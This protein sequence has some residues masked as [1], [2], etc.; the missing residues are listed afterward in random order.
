MFCESTLGV[1]SD[2][3][4]QGLTD[5]ELWFKL[6]E[7]PNFRIRTVKDVEGVCLCGGMKNII[8]LAA[9]FSDGLGWGSNTKAAII[10]IGLTEMKDFSLRFF[11]STQAETF[12]QESCG[13]ADLVTTCISGRNRMIGEEMAK[14]GKGFQELEREKLNGQ[15]LEGPQTVDQVHGFMVLHGD[16]VRKYG[17]YRLLENVWKICFQGLSPDKVL[18]GV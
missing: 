12:F 5:S 14:S 3:P 15:Q 2:A 13:V 10:R 6:F 1:P 18:E 11:P 17:G 9:G 8:A 4:D 16:E 7:T